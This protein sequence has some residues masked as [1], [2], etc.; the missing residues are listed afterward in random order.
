MGE[1]AKRQYHRMRMKLR[2]NVRRQKKQVELITEQADTSLEKYLFKRFNRLQYVRRFVITWSVLLILIGLGSAW[3]V[4]GLDNYYLELVPTSGGVYREGLIGTFTTANPLFAVGSADV[5]VSR[6]VFSALFKLA[7]DG[8]LE[9]DLATSFQ[10]DET[11]TVYTV[12]LKENVQWHDGS[13]LTA[14]DVAFTYSSI[15]NSEVK[16]P[17]YSGWSLIQVAVIDP[18]TV[19][20]TLPNTL[21]SFGYSM[22]NGIV[23]KHILS[24]IAPADLRSASFN[25]VNPIGTGPFKYRSVEVLGDNIDSRREKVTLERF[26]AYHGSLPQIE[27]VSIR[28]FRDEETMLEAFDEKEISAM[29]GLQTISDTLAQDETVQTFSS[30][31]SSQVMVFFNTSSPI[32]SDVVVRRALLRATDTTAL[33]QSVG[34]NLIASDSP[35]LK[36]HFT[37]DN[38][39]TQPPHDPTE[40]KKL[41]D[42]AGWVVAEDGMRVKDGQQLTIRLISQ[43]LTEYA[44]VV[45]GLQQQWGDLGVKV[46]AILQP[47]EDVQSGAVV[48]HDYDVLLYGISLGPDPDV[49]AYWHSSQADPRVK[50]RLNLSEYSNKV[51]DSALEAGRTRTDQALRKLK[52]QPFVDAWLNDVPAIALYQPRFLF[53]VRGTLEGYKSGQ[54]TNGT[55]R[56]YSISDWLIRKDKKIK[57]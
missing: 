44:T 57:Q 28:T 13:K 24:S 49:F 11:G 53:V 41:F 4:R 25:T 19:Q 3:Q 34:Y 12:T 15:K 1:A 37:Y 22:T 30:P 39:K 52:Y 48:R 10:V 47:E 2:R 35:F 38:T 50:S 31:L 17:L 7:P 46:D 26:E 18:V 54:F 51:A 16:S 5:S 45:Q 9:P 43:S 36:S 23:P 29:V 6:L 20:F 27:G 42:E 33:R 55:D 14:E 8:T 32:L 40:A 21:S 56:F